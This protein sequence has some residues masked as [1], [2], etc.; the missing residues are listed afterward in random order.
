MS[1]VNESEPNGPGRCLDLR[2]EHDEAMAAAGRAVC[3]GRPI[4]LPTDTVY[5]VGVDPFSPEAVQGLLDAKCRGRDMPP[6]VLIAEPGMLPA[7][8]SAVPPGARRMIARF[9]P[10]ALTLILRAPTS[11]RMDLGESGGTIA[12]RVPDH[13]DARELL[14]RTGPLAVSSANVS[15]R[16]P[17]TDVAAAR[18]MLG[19]SVAVYLDGGP[20]PGPTASTIVDFTRG[21][22]GR[23]LRAGVIGFEALRECSPGLEGLPRADGGPDAEPVRSSRPADA[24]RDDRTGG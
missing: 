8:A 17:A 5:G 2:T 11:L 6:P 21:Y 16:P 23:M 12:V 10:G 13:D 18:S 15:G 19:D 7:L 20:T 1:A 14:R 24:G 3:E 9:W 4:V 22:G